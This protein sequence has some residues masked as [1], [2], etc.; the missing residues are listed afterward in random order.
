MSDEDW[1]ELDLQTCA[2]IRL[3][4][5]RDVQVSVR[6]ETTIVRIWQKLEDQYMTKNLTNRLY[7]KKSLYRM[8]M[9]EGTSIRDHI[10]KFKRVVS[11]LLDV[12]VK[13]EEE[14]QALTLL[15]SLPD[16]YENLVQTMLYGKATITMDEATSA[17]L[18]DQIRKMAS[19]NSQSNQQR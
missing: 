9:D 2:T 1:E 7:Q 15:F 11:N 10:A 8:T 14:D 13:I 5:A 3:C 18:S 6:E 19:G 17:L 16:S 12:D 4:L